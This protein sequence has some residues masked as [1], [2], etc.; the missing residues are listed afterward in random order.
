MK[1][2]VSLVIEQTLPL[3]AAAMRCASIASGYF[4][5]LMLIFARKKF[6]EM[7][8]DAPHGIKAVCQD[9]GWITQVLIAEYSEQFYKFVKPSKESPVLLI[10]DNHSFHIS[11]AAVNSC[12][13]DGTAMVSLP[14][15]CSHKLQPLDTSFF[16]PLKTYYTTA[17]ENWMFNSPGKTY[18]KT[19]SKTR[20]CRMRLLLCNCNI[21]NLFV[22]HVSFY[23]FE[24]TSI[25]SRS[26]LSR[27]AKIFHV[28][29]IAEHLYMERR[30]SIIKSVQNSYRH[31]GKRLS[32]EQIQN[33]A[34]GEK[35]PASKSSSTVRPEL[36]EMY[37]VPPAEDWIH[38]V[39]VAKCG[40][41]KHLK[42]QLGNRING[43]S[44][45]NGFRAID[46]K[47]RSYFKLRISLIV[48]LRCADQRQILEFSVHCSKFA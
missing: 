36:S 35:K 4:L 38:S 23:I 20:W 30:S 33:K 12:R 10:V 13:E 39:M 15:H 48:R 34:R 27:T 31:S 21:W 8:E 46:A 25:Q 28:D 6:P 7:T 3:R 17:C 2:A 18:R 32:P 9:K 29:I 44:A 47:I 19:D 24:W 40:T 26:I 5:P 43:F 14:P 22:S 41:M 16:G 45:I 11:L 1:I 37:D 42:R